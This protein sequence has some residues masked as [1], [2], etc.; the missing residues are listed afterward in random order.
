MPVFCVLFRPVRPGFFDGPTEAEQESIGR[1]FVR[2]RDGYEAGQV[3]FVGR[4]ED[5]TFGICV[6]EAGSLGEAESWAA[7]DAAVADGVFSSEVR[8]FRTVFSR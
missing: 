2:I 3:H 5:A 6:M 4:C 7:S 1:H 8:E